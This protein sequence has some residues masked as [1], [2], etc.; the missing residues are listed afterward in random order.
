MV[1]QTDLKIKTQIEYY[2]S[3]KNL[4]KDKFFRD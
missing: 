1:E 2:M 4:M 3:D